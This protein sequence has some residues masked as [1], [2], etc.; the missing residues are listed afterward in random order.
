MKFI[1]L[2]F[3]ST[4]VHAETWKT[5]TFNVS[6]SKNQDGDWV[7]RD[8][9]KDCS[10]SDKVSENLKK[11]G[12][13]H[14]ELQGGLNPGSVLCKRIRGKVI[15]LTRG[16]VSQAFCSLGTS[17]VSLSLLIRKLNGSDTK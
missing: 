15:Y 2:I 7:S 16:D 17:T 5:G 9:L 4:L 13:T 10:I 3:L 11:L 8:C 14:N 12:L 1:L 6:L